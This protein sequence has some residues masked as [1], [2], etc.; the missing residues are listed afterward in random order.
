MASTIFEVG[1]QNNF[2]LDSIGVAITEPLQPIQG[3]DYMFSSTKENILR[4]FPYL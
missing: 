4:V 1:L 3:I 2:K